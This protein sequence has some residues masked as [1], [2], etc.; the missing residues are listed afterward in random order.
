MFL[1]RL[2]Y[3]SDDHEFTLH[4]SLYDYN[5]SLYDYKV[6]SHDISLWWGNEIYKGTGQWKEDVQPLTEQC[7]E[8]TKS[9]RK[10]GKLV[11]LPVP[12]RLPIS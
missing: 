11:L 3:D 5:I 2:L 10:G 12:Q 4:L 7:K 6:I 9:P 1:N 8:L